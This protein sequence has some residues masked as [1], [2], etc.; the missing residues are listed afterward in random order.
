MEDVLFSTTDPLGHN[1]RL[2]NR[3]YQFHILIAHPDLDNLNEIEQS[4]RLAEYIA[5]DAVD[6]QRIVYYKTYQRRPQRWFIKVVVDE[7]GEVVTAYRVKRIKQSEM[8]LWQR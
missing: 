7:E 1:V 4:I 6:P 2:T 3:C 5:Q 8:I